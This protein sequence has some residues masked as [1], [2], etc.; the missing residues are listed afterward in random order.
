MSYKPKKYRLSYKVEKIKRRAFLVT[1]ANASQYGND[2]FISPFADIQ[3]G[4]LDVCIF[5]PFP[6]FKTIRL[7]ISL[8]RKKIHETGY[9]EIFRTDEV[10][11][12]RKRKDVFH[13]DGEP[14]IL[15]KKVKL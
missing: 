3:D 6:K 11:L 5:K 14:M 8:F 1:F 13:C 9:V 7:A 12:K 10:T 2:A 15:K 4:K